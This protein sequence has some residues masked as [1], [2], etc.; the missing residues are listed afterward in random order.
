MEK[1]GG[2]AEPEET[3]PPKPWCFQEVNRLKITTIRSLRWR[4]AAITSNREKVKI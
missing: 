4:A 1:D 3:T 2:E